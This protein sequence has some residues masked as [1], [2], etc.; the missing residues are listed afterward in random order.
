MREMEKAPKDY[1][2]YVSELGDRPALAFIIYK[3]NDWI[4]QFEYFRGFKFCAE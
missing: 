2:V 3:N 1:N 4:K